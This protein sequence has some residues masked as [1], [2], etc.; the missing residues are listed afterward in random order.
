M[1]VESDLFH[2]KLGVF[3]VCVHQFDF[4]M[5]RQNLIFAFCNISFKSKSDLVLIYKCLCNFD[6]QLFFRILIAWLVIYSVK[7]FAKASFSRRKCNL[8]F[9][10]A[11]LHNIL[12]LKV[13]CDHSCAIAFFK[14]LQIETIAKHFL[15]SCEW[16]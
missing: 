13:V 7:F 11:W 9:L 8:I 2:V 5:Y 12:Y 15:N 16:F 6:G 14:N 3:Y 1:D 4:F 10:F